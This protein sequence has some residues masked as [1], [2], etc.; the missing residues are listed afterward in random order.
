MNIKIFPIILILAVFGAVFPSAETVHSRIK[1]Y[2][3][4]DTG[5]GGCYNSMYLTDCPEK[6][7]AFL[8]QDTQYN[9]AQP[10]YTD[11]GD[12]TVTDNNTGLMWQKDPG[13]KMTFD[14]AAEGA[15]YFN[16][17]GYTDWRLPTIKELYSL[18]Q[19]SGLDP[20]V[21]SGDTS[22]LTP[23]I[24]TDYFDFEYGDTSA[25]ERI[26]DSQFASSNIYV[27]HGM[28]AKVM[29]G[30]NFA[31]GRIKGYPAIS[32]HGNF[33][34]T[35]YVLYVRGNEDYGSNDFK[36]N[37]NG[38]VQDRATGLTWQQSD[39]GKGY[40]WEDALS[41]CEDLDLA[42]QTDW[43]LPNAKELQSIVDYTRAPDLG[44]PAIDPVFRTTAITNEAGQ[45]DWPWFWTATTHA[46][47]HSGDTAAYIAFGRALGFMHGSWIDVH[48]AGAQRSDPKSGDPAA[49]P[50]GRGPQGDAIRIYNF[51]RCVRG[52]ASFSNTKGIRLEDTNYGKRNPGDRP[53]QGNMQSS[54]PGGNMHGPQGG[55]MQGPPGEHQPP[56]Q[57]FDACSGKIPGAA[58]SFD[59]PHG[60]VTG[61]CDYGMESDLICIPEHR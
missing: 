50:Y 32:M 17:A 44:S 1:S 55:N 21:M 15:H 31:D 4:V 43:R 5:Q 56:A 51:A 61:A 6:G 25:G 60:A 29:F 54:S 49:F 3:I 8:G 57:A 18:I 33:Q 30:V 7:S 35:F 12:G 26:I 59:A 40:T 46:R 52:G 23:F 47:I 48:G 13:R 20:D 19:F 22:G 27:G 24:D 53:P 42:G 14:E 36:D 9:G 16:L 28:D 38:T 2:T 10:S 41:Y 11:N 39:S 37:G 45:K 34:K 58:C